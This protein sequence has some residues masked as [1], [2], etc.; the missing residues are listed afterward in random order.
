MNFFVAFTC[1]CS[2]KIDGQYYKYKQ[3]FIYHDE[4]WLWNGYF[5]GITSVVRVNVWSSHSQRGLWPFGEHQQLS[6]IIQQPIFMITQGCYQHPGCWLEL[7]LLMH[8]V[9]V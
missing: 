5:M 6:K 8:W 1:A 4:E 2:N 3:L 9:Q 7:S